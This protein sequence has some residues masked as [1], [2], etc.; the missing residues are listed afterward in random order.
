VLRATDAFSCGFR[1]LLQSPEHAQRLRQKD[2]ALEVFLTNVRRFAKEFGR[3]SDVA[4]C[5]AGSREVVMGVEQMRIDANGLF[6]LRCGLVVAPRQR[7]HER[8]RHVRLSKIRREFQCL[9]T[10]AFCLRQVV[11]SRAKP[12]VEDRVHR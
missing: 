2:R 12:F 5:E 10:G 6:E 1:R 7:Q 8:P 9:F 4:A 11:F 3:A